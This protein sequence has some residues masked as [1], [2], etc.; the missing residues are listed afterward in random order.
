MRKFLLSLTFAVISL[1][2]YA[3]DILVRKNGDA[4]NV[5]VME[6]SPTEIK[7]KKSSNPNGP[8]FIEKR[9]DIYSVKYENG[10]VQT[11]GTKEEK[12]HKSRTFSSAYDEVKN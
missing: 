10:E 5:K 8:T 6:V 3:Q 2:T 4:E 7:F 9:S 12:N 11:F 1:S